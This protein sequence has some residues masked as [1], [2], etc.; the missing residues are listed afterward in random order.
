[1]AAGPGFRGIL[2]TALALAVAAHADPARAIAQRIG[3]FEIELDAPWRI[4]P[5][6]ISPFECQRGEPCDR[7]GYRAIPLQISIH[8]ADQPSGYPSSTLQQLITLKQAG[9]PWYDVVFT[10]LIDAL[11]SALGSVIDAIA[12][13]FGLDL[14]PDNILPPVVTLQSFRAL[15]VYEEISGQYVLRRSYGIDD[16]HEVERTVGLWQWAASQ[17]GPEAPGLPPARPAWSL[18][19]RWQGDSCAGFAAL[20]PTSEWHATTFYAPNELGAGGDVHLRLALDLD[21]LSGGHPVTGTVSRELVVHLGELPLP[22]FDSRW[23]YGD[24]HYHSQ[25][26]D[27]DGE[28]AYSYRGALQGMAAIGLD[29][30]FATDHASNSRQLGAVQPLPARALVQPL[31]R[32]LRDLSP[33]R[34]AFA[35]ALLNGP[36]GANPQVT[37]FVRRTATG[38]LVAPQLFLGAEV[39]VIPEFDP[40]DFHTG[41]N[42]FQCTELPG[43]LKAL[44]QVT[45]FPSDY[46]CDSMVDVTSEGRWLLRDVQGPVGTQEL[47]STRFYGRQHLLHLPTDPQR[48]T[49]F[50]PSNTSLYGGATRRLG[51]ILSVELGQRAKGVAFLAHPFSH[52]EGSGFERL[53]PDEMSYSD[54][55]LRQALASPHVLGLQLWNGDAMRRASATDSAPF[56][57][58]SWD[59][60]ER[61]ASLVRNLWRW[62]VWL[63]WGL[64]RDN[65]APL[66]WLPAGDPRRVFVAGGSDAHGDLNY[67]R[68][69][70][71]FGTD[72]A[73][74]TALGMPRNLVEAGEPQGAIAA[75]AGSAQPFTQAQVVSALQRGAFSV[76]DGPALR[77]AY[78]ANANGMIDAGDV[79]MGGI[80]RPTACSSRIVVEWKSTPEFGAVQFVDLYLGVHS[81]VLDASWVYAPW[82]D[83]GYSQSDIGGSVAWVDPQS[84]IT[85]VRTPHPRYW[86]DP[87]PDTLG[88]TPV[89]GEEYAG[90]RVITIDPSDFPLGRTVCVRDPSKPVDPG[91]GGNEP[92]LD[93]EERRF[94]DAVRPD[95]VYVRA[96]IR[97]VR[98]PGTPSDCSDASMVGTIPCIHRQAL[99]NPIWLV[100]AGAQLSC[101]RTGVQPPPDPGP[102][103]DLDSDQDGLPDAIDGCPYYIQT[104]VADSDGDGRWDECECGD[105]NGDGRT[106]VTDVVAL[107][108]AIFDPSQLG[109]LCDADNDQVCNVADI[110][111]VNRELFSIGNTSTCARQPVAGP[112]RP[113]YPFLYSGVVYGTARR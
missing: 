91:S 2:T 103:R 86:Y 108:R 59:V 82:R 83:V 87:T 26:T 41:T 65:T 7:H 73:N 15:R 24:L 58:A 19:R 100:P 85:Y 30:A 25:G 53:G 13:L 104:A 106:S 84:G 102:A 101:R 71:F 78:D 51:E 74:D 109:P 98:A 31:F 18:C 23:A 28:S 48:A 20:R 93:C 6:P 5:H 14:V 9:T 46:W 94:E 113:L 105:Q 38:G 8:D 68:A 97:N 32:G 69:G 75:A 112:N 79:P 27:N 45:I 16:L 10:F 37:S 54:F 56:D 63:L 111:A 35:L 92:D 49:A 60:Q 33:D 40:A 11:A 36:T 110:L 80:A 90:R 21:V 1:M 96:E 17:T 70:Y 107:N 99:G 50:I 47:L 4:E 95:R 44:D 66:T 3:D 77:I 61:Q 43:L 89:A 64:D 67:R 22:R 55:E 29:F 81:S 52:P 12:G 57:G 39:D 88:I 42:R 34:F 62:D 76:T 72:G